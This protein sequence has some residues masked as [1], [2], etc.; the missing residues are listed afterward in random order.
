MIAV[1]KTVLSQSQE[2]QNPLGTANAVNHPIRAAFSKTYF[3]L[4]LLLLAAFAVQ[5]I[6]GLT[7]PWLA[8]LQANHLYKQLS[9][10]V[11]IAYLAHQ[12]YCSLLRN[13]GFMQRALKLL[14]RHKFVGA[15]APV[16]F[17]AHAQHIGYAYLQVLS[18]V[19][20]TIFLTGLFNVEIT[21]IR[22][23]RF[24]N[25]WI[26]VHVGLTTGLMFLVAYHIFISYYY[27]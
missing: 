15:L 21:R 22:E 24:Q 14:N 5:D 2:G 25:L 23:H 12:W 17:Y 3:W 20:F 4:G 9:G 6:A 27:Q 10:L 16:F 8:E 7:W 1:N 18:L 26:T 11:L 19:Y 13:R